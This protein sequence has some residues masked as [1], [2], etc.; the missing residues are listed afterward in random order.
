MTWKQHLTPKKPT[1]YLPL[2][3]ILFSAL[4][5]STII[6]VLKSSTRTPAVKKEHPNNN[7]N[8]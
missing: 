6:K 7:K 2:M 5:I 8:L 3:L 1:N 4:R